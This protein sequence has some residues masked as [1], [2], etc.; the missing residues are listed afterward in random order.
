MR[1]ERIYAN[2]NSYTY[3]YAVQLT[4][5]SPVSDGIQPDVNQQP[6]LWVNCAHEL[7]VRNCEV[8]IRPNHIAHKLG[9]R[10]GAFA[11]DVLHEVESST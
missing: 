3:M 2:F 4:Y 9:Y 8:R 6:K 11:G 1:N 5:L 7:W 10:A